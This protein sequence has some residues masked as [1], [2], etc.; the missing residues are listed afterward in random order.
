MSVHHRM[1]VVLGLLAAALLLV[2]IPALADDAHKHGDTAAAKAQ[3]EAMMAE[4]MKFAAP[5]EM[6]AF[7]KPMEGKWKTTTTTYMG[8]DK[9]TSEGTCERTWIMGDRFLQSKYSGTMGP[10]MP[11]FEGMEI[12][13]F[14]TR[15]NSLQSTWIDNMGTGMYPSSKGT[16][17]K[18]SKTMTVYTDFFDPMTKKMKTY[19]RVTK[20]VD[21]DNAMFALIGNVNGKD[22]TEMEIA[23][24]RA[25]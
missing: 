10:N 15:T 16:I 2:T 25:K 24:T 14:D 21:N 7:L 6:H 11:P 17:D 12:L 18:A 8:G 20:S 13:G 1:P 23:Y 3:E 9:Q 22:V 5:G 19:K 4:M